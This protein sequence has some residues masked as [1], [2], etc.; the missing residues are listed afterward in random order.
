SDRG[1]TRSTIREFDL[2]A[3]TFVKNGF[4][5][6][7]NLVHHALW[8]DPDTLYVATD[9]GPGSLS[10]EGQPL[11]VKEWRRGEAL[12]AARERFR[13]SAD[14]PPISSRTARDGRGE[15]PLTAQKRHGQ[16]SPLQ[17]IHWMLPANGPAQRLFVP[18]SCSISARYRDHWICYVV[19]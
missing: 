18:P 6:P 11:I 1:S 4:T 3:R 17:Y 2:S 9:F 8:K 13:L 5:L 12:S 7:P 15:R 10:K 14:D 16:S 19:S